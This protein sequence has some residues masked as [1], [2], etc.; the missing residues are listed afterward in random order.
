ML[1]DPQTR[2]S[3]DFL[4][5]GDVLATRAPRLL[6]DGLKN[7]HVNKGLVWENDAV[8]L[9]L[10]EAGPGQA[11]LVASPRW[12]ADAASASQAAYNEIGRVLQDQGLAIVH[13]RLFGS[14]TVKAGSHGLPLCSLPRQKPPGRWPSH[15][16]TGSSPRGRGFGRGYHPGGILLSSPG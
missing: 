12:G 13:E 10:T 6:H 5:W 7:R 16:R 8:R 2:A 11:Y 1:G 3:A 15:L 4:P 14:L 9:V